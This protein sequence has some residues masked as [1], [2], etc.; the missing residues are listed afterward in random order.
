VKIL[1][2]GGA[3][4]I[5]SHIVDALV[6]RG[7]EVTIVDDRSTGVR[8][9]VNPAAE[10]H[11]LDIRSAQAAALVRERRPDAICH[12]AAQMSVSQSVREPI[13]TTDINVMGSLNLLDAAR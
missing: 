6:A 10:F 13:A 4:F 2:T 9:Y 8:E 1:V 7:D 3:G 12:Q 11:H 5:G